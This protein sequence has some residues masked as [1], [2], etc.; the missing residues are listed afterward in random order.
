[1]QKGSDS[2][3][4]PLP[5][6]TSCA[7]MA[8]ISLSSA[9]TTQSL[10]PVGGI[11]C[12]LLPLFFNK[13]VCL[14]RL[15]YDLL[16]MMTIICICWFVKDSHE[17]VLIAL[18]PL[19]NICM[20][21]LCILCSEN[22]W[23]LLSFCHFGFLSFCHSIFPFSILSTEWEDKAWMNDGMNEWLGWRNEWMI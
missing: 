2:G 1:M 14:S 16:V 13:F 15:F 12:S 10:P 18:Q 5:V 11:V 19:L 3:R 4:G 9:S 21:F 23:C 20:S 7:S 22:S 8:Q 17:S 6:T